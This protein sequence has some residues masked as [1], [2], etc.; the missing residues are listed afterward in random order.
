MSS[1]LFLQA[2]VQHPGALPE[3]LGQFLPLRSAPACPCHHRLWLTPCPAFLNSFYLTLCLLGTAWC[4]PDGVSRAGLWLV[5]PP[6]VRPAGVFPWFFDPGKGYVPCSSS[7]PHHKGSP[8]SA[9]PSPGGEITELVFGP[10]S[11]QPGVTSWVLPAPLLSASSRRMA[12]PLAPTPW[13][14]GLWSPGPC[15][16]PVRE[17][18]QRWEAVACG[19]LG[20]TR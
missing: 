8:S 17:R 10:W 3:M 20:V 1:C 6:W 18:C 4:C 16:S 11:K 14:L 2:G 9:V 7:P 13:L 19:G 12:S 5:P 15:P